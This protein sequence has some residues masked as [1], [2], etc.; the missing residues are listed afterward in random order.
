MRK[1]IVGRAAVCCAQFRA[2]ESAHVHAGLHAR[3]HAHVRDCRR[4]V[5]RPER[6]DSS[7]VSSKAHQIEVGELPGNDKGV[8]NSQEKISK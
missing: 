8:Q 3:T 4:R 6:A 5:K 2:R 1:W 7:G